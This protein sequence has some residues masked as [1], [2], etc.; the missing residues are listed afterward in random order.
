[1]SGQTLPISDIWFVRAEK[2]NALANHYLEQGVVTMGWGIG[3]IG[4]DDSKEEIARRLDSK[5]PNEKPRTIQSWAAEI[6]RFIKEIGV[7]DAVATIS[8]PQGES[9]LCH[10]GIIQSLLFTM[11][12]SPLYE[13]HDIDYVRQVKW[14][15]HVPTDV[16]SEFTQRRLSI[17]LTLHRLSSEAS[18]ELRQHCP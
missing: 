6:L 11:E 16:L 12:P 8:S 9:R 10:V 3:P 1:M 5:Y 18:A 17:P 14:L 15:Y 7:G 2:A 13:Q 4:Y